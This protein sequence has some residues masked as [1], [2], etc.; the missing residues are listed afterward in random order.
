M[1][2]VLFSYLVFV[3]PLLHFTLKVS[4]PPNDYEIRVLYRQ[5]YT[6]ICMFAKLKPTLRIYSPSGTRIELKMI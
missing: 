2:N 4:P 5:Y 3:D 6:F 1:R